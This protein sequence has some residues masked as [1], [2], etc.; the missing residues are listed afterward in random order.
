MTTPNNLD[1]VLEPGEPQVLTTGF[2][3][4]EGPLWHPPTP[5]YPDGA[6]YVSDVDTAIHYLVDAKTGE[7]TV[8]RENDG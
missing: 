6:M 3:F 5:E 1:R 4:A 7:K 8:L 2:H